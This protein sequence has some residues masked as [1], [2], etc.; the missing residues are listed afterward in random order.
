MPTLEQALASFSKTLEDSRQRS[1]QP[2]PEPPTS[3]KQTALTPL[4]GGL[5]GTGSAQTVKTLLN[6]IG[7]VHGKTGAIGRPLEATTPEEQLQHLVATSL[8][9]PL[10][11][12]LAWKQKT[13]ETGMAVYPLVPQPEMTTQLK[14]LLQTNLAQ[15]DKILIP[16]A[17]NPG[18]L[19]GVVTR[20]FAVF[21]QFTGDEAKVEAQVDA[22]V[23]ELKEYPLWAIYKAY[24]WSARAERKMPS[25]S[26]FIADV[27]LAVGTDV[28][29]RQRL[30]KQLA[31]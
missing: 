20:L 28:L 29:G 15:L 16:A 7:E 2:T 19:I 18:R 3:G 17:S 5:V 26:E 11:Q 13:A 14:T 1:G 9:L 21:N 30:L 24:K 6:A 25:L 22:W 23:E 10:N 8:P 31:A 12:W 27:K 4:G